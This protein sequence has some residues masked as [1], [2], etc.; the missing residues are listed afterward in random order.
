MSATSLNLAREAKEMLLQSWPWRTILSPEA[1]KINHPFCPAT[2]NWAQ[3]LI[4]KAEGKMSASVRYDASHATRCHDGC[5][6]LHII[7]DVMQIVIDFN[8]FSFQ[9]KFECCL[10]SG[11]VTSM[12]RECCGA[13]TCEW[14]R[15]I[16]PLQSIV[17]RKIE[18]MFMKSGFFALALSF[19]H[20]LRLVPLLAVGW[21][22][23]F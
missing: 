16:W 6:Y 5:R 7:A 3:D 10:R 19:D 9:K 2:G 12:E 13:N 1:E 23:Q 17:I 21:S 8:G 22:N 14:L 4:Y 18:I 15:K 11:R 20:G